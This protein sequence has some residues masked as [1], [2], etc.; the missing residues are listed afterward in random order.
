MVERIE[1]LLPGVSVQ[2]AQDADWIEA[3]MM[4]WL[5]YK[6]IRKEPIPLSDV[7]GARENRILGGVYE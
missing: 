6:R 4:A 2:I 7:T 5:A 1:A 3:M